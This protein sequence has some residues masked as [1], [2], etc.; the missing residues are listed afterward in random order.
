MNIR[1][2]LSN[3]LLTLTKLE[4]DF[5]DKYNDPSLFKQIN[6]YKKSLAFYMN[7][8]N[9]NRAMLE[10]EYLVCFLITYLTN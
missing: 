5:K 8:K 3:N 2:K 4:T 10:S 9:Y 1:Q 7:N 6:L